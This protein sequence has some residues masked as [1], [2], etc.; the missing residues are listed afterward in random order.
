MAKQIVVLALMFF[1]AVGMASS[2]APTTSTSPSLAPTTGGLAEGPNGDDGSTIGTISGGSA[3]DAA[4]VGGP[5][6]NGVFPDLT[7]APAPAPANGAAALEVTTVAGAIAA[8]GVVGSFF[9]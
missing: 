9:F 4:P 5:V 2:I 7:P 3:F 8:A 1:A 6:P